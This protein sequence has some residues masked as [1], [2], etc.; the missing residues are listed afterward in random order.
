MIP[1]AGETQPADVTVCLNRG[2]KIRVWFDKAHLY[3]VSGP[4]R[5]DSYGFERPCDFDSYKEMMN[6]YV[7]V[8]NRR[9]MRW[10]RLLQQ[11]P[12]VEKNL[13]GAK[14]V[15]SLLI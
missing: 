7:G 9:S 1:S 15:N 14:D 11:K 13:T 6:Q 3:V 5:V 4:G 12:E 2:K 10:S 8:L